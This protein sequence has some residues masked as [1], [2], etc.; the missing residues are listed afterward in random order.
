MDRVHRRCQP[1]TSRETIYIVIAMRTIRWVLLMLPLTLAAAQDRLKTM[2][3][4]EQAQRLAREAPTAMAGG[5]LRATWTEGS[6]AFEYDRDGRRYRY[7]VA[8][9]QATEIGGA[10]G[11]GRA[12]EAG[13]AGTAP[14]RGRQFEST[15]SPDGALKAFY[16]D[17]NVWLSAA[18]GSGARAITTDGSAAGRIKYGTA[19][20]V[21]GEELSQRTAMW[22]SPDSRKLAY[23][24]FDER[25]VRDYYVTLNQTRPQVTLDIEAFPTAG[26]PNPTVD[27]FVYDVATRE[28]VRVDVRD[29]KP[30]DNTSIGHY[31]YR[32]SWS[33][34]GRELLF[35]RMN[36]RQNVMEV[37][38][39]DAGDRRLPSRAARRVADRL[40]HGRAAD[41]V[42][43]GRDALHLGVAAQRLEQ[44]LS[45]RSQGRFDRAAHDLHHRRRG[46]R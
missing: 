20:W 39:A 46:Q 10:G 15:T 8:T 24:R 33:A 6:K 22:W 42:S 30:F 28:T 31:V 21:Y 36:R 3:G 25:Q 2:P 12:G 16:N 19:S 13:G 18:D 7:D 4:Y 38:A 14:E 44:F 27:L 11:A 35:L 9:L 1:G 43:R 17:R 5:A 40:G 37:A 32:V 34:D 45:L 29:G 26:T 23:Y 41:G